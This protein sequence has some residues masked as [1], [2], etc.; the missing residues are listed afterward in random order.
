[1]QHA[2]RKDDNSTCPKTK[3]PSKNSKSHHWLWLLFP[4]TGLLA[5]IWFLVRVIPK[6][7]RATYPCQRVAFP[8]ASGF[9]IW[10]MGL[11]GSVAAFRKAKKYMTKARY[12]TASICIVTSVAFIWAAMSNTTQEIIYGQEPVAN[13]PIGE[14]KGVY[15]GRVAWIHDANAT[16]WVYTSQYQSEHWFESEHTNQEVVSRMMSKA[17]RALTGENS[18]Y[19]AW[20]AI[21]R[22]FNQQMG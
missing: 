22:N 18:D 14:A 7:S 10:L 15:P 2:K 11:I 13:E 12:I 3:K 17:L 9:I 5:L 20:D 4:V 19:D 8:L 21:F 16:D 1:M 6:P